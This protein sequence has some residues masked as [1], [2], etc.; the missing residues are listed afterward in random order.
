MAEPHR[1][2]SR[3]SIHPMQ[4]GVA[5]LGAPL[6][7]VCARANKFSISIRESTLLKKEAHTQNARTSA[8]ATAAGCCLA[9]VQN[10]ALGG[11]GYE[12]QSANTNIKYTR[13]IIIARI[14]DTQHLK[15]ECS[16]HIH[17]TKSELRL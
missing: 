4:K 5:D 6:K 12:N 15:S 9:I 1:N 8:A 2:K 10:N 17:Q 14:E 3:T 7:R 16:G 11:G 13:N